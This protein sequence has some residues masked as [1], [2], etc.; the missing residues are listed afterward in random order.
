M[1]FLSDN[2]PGR[3]AVGRGH[4]I[5]RNKEYSP[6]QDIVIYD[7]IRGVSIPIDRYYSLFLC[8][9]VWAT[10]E[11][12]SELTASDGPTGP[13]GDLWD[14]LKNIT[15]VKSLRAKNRIFCAVFAYT[16][17]WR[18]EP[19]QK[20]VHW[21]THLG[22][23]YQKNIP[24]ITLVLD[25]GFLIWPAGPTGYYTRGSSLGAN[26]KYPLLQFVSR[27]IRVPEDTADQTPDLWF[28]YG[29]TLE[30]GLEQRQYK[31][32]VSPPS[33]K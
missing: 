4:I 18:D 15:K 29:D 31:L 7:A 5:N 17:G 30:G 23:K 8:E 25:P 33:G 27:L 20:V 28:G 3:F 10:I 14:C 9:S 24:D 26:S 32:Q 19:E 6:Q 2:L 16:T 1:D 11:V 12:K 21:M 22:H 13:R